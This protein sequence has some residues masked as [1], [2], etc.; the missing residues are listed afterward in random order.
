[1][2]KTSSGICNVVPGKP[3]F[4]ARI[5]APFRKALRLVGTVK[6]WGG[7]LS[8]GEVFGCF[9]LRSDRMY[10]RTLFL[11][12]IGNYSY[13]IFVCWI[14]DISLGETFMLFLLHWLGVVLLSLFWFL[15]PQIS[16]WNIWR[17]LCLPSPIELISCCERD[18]ILWLQR[19]WQWNLH[20]KAFLNEAALVLILLWSLII[21]WLLVKEFGKWEAAAFE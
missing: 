14:L 2:G 4:I 21:A 9:F 11:C 17:C 7:T 13:S 16:F 6:W 8:V 3:T 12:H 18:V 19:K 20:R 5:T 1:M 15:P 10:T